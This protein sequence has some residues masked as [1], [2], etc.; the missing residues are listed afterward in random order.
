LKVESPNPAAETL[1]AFRALSDP[2]RARIVRVLASG[3]F[4][5]NEL[6]EILGAQ[7]S[8]VSRHLRLLSEANLVTCRRSKTWAYYSLSQHDGKRF[9][10]RL[11][12]LL[13]GEWEASPNPEE[14]G[15]E[16][17]LARRRRATSEFFRKSA[18]KWDGLRDRMLGSS[19]H[20]EHI[21]AGIAL[22]DAVV[23]DLGTGTGVLLERLSTR[24]RKVIG[25]DSSPEMLE[26]ARRR[27]RDSGL[28][29][30]E[31]RLGAL[32]HLPLSD[33]EA[34]AM[35]ANL[36][37]H[38]VADVPEVLR[39]IRRCLAPGGQLV[40]AELTEGGN[41]SFWQ[42]IGAQWPGFRPADLR[43]KLEASGFRVE[44]EET[45]G[46]IAM[47]MNGPSELSDAKTNRNRDPN[48][49]LQTNGNWETNGNSGAQ[50]RPEIL[51][52]NARRME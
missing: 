5:V 13:A 50:N 37:L 27:S 46:E 36:V 42:S 44:R 31:L 4:H 1:A 21:I 47:E 34:T 49:N 11:L 2:T 22:E 9:P 30:T 24:A 41:E 17:V 25:I 29:N 12:E 38:H 14:A 40:I 52:L 45:L 23:V 33:Q 15:I 8:T 20:L 48:G 26:I 3:P 51:F 19:S 16:A 39:E 43:Q 28:A 32:E 7:Q 35:V 6:T 10:A 18:G